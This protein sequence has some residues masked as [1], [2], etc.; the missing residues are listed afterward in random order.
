[1][2]AAGST[3]VQ[4]QKLEKPEP[5][6]CL[7][8]SAR[9]IILEEGLPRRRFRR[10]SRS[11]RGLGSGLRGGDD[12]AVVL[13]G[14]VVDGVDVPERGAAWRDEA[15]R[16]SHMKASQQKHAHAVLRCTIPIFFKGQ[17]SKVIRSKV[18]SSRRADGCGA[19]DEEVSLDVAD[20]PRR[21]VLQQ[22]VGLFLHAHAR[23]T[24]QERKNVVWCCGKRAAGGLFWKHRK[25][26]TQG[27][28]LRFFK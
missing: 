22:P 15:R 20:V 3:Y 9:P 17:R 27:S 19:R 7:S 8:I 5:A 21:V 1:V 2:Q 14:V 16:G 4:P 28:L 6:S 26:C 18:K 12:A 11:G 25:C 10:G 13:D 23:H 24:P